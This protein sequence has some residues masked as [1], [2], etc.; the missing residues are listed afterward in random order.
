MARERYL[1]D[2]DPSEIRSEEKR[3]LTAKEKRKN[4]WYYNKWKFLIGALLIAL[5]VYFIASVV[6]RV[7]PDYE[8]AL[9]TPGGFSDPALEQFE[10]KRASLGEDRNGDGKVVVQINKYSFGN[11]SGQ[12]AMVDTAKIVAD[13]DA[14][15]SMIFI[16]DTVSLDNLI[17]SV[18]S[19]FFVDLET[20]DPVP[21][22]LNDLTPIRAP[23]PEW[24]AFEDF[25]LDD[26]YF[27]TDSDEY[28]EKLMGRLRISL[29]TIVDT[30]H[31]DSKSK[32]EYFE[33]SKT[34]VERV[35]SGEMPSEKTE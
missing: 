24:K 31:E 27:H 11:T 16:T 7:K 13:L 5:A 2:V 23:Y 28:T 12:T 32:Q 6:M 14:C 8:I 15:Q 34:L 19:S 21:D 35:L 4:F 20:W 30:R 29:R 10:S 17:P 18:G 22:N 25:R 26:V 9:M 3:E 33:A 1:V